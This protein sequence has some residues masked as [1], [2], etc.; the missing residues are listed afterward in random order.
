MTAVG[1][2]AVGMAAVGMAAVGMATP[3]R[4]RMLVTV[5]SGS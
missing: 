1:M 5:T 4:R 3:R 2:T